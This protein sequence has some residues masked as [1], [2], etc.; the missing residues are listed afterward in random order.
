M[1]T[2]PPPNPTAATSTDTVLDNLRPGSPLQPQISA[3]LNAALKSQLAAA[4]TA[5]QLPALVGLINSMP[6]VDLVA[7]KDLSLHD[8]VSKEVSLPADP[9]EKA[10]LENA[11]G[12]LS[13]STTV[14]D[15][16]GL[17]LTIKAN[18]IAAPEANKA[19]LTTLL[20]ASA[21]LAANSKLI[22]EFVTRYAGFTGSM[23]DFWS[24]LSQDSEFKAVVPELQLT[25]QL[26]TLTLDNPVLVAAL[27]TRYPQMT[28]PRDLTAMSADDWE[29]LITSQHVAIPASISGSTP[30]EQVA[31]YAAA[32]LVTLKEA[33]PGSVFGQALEK[34]LAGSTNTVDRNVSAVLGRASDFD[35]LNT[36]LA[37]YLTQH[38]ATLFTGIAV[39]DQ[40]AV[41]ERLATWQRVARVTTDFP[42]ANTL[43]T[44]G[45]TSAYGI[46][47]TPRASF[48]HAFAGALGSTNAEAI[49]GRAQQISGTAMALFTN[50]RQ[51]LTGV[52]VTSIGDVGGLVWKIQSAPSG[53]PNWQ[54]LFGPLS[55]CTC[56]DCQSVYSAAA[57]F[58]DLLHFLASPSTKN[59]AGQTALH[60]LFVRRPDLQYIKLNCV[61]TNT[62]LPYVDLV[63]EIMESF[64][65]LSSAAF[66]ATLNA[67]TAH[68]TAKS[69]TAADLSVSPEYTLDD[70]YNKYLNTALYPPTLP[71]DRWLLT[72]RTYLGFLGS[73]LYEVMAT[74][75]TAAAPAVYSVPLSK[76]PSIALPSFVTYDSV[77]HRLSLTGAMTADAKTALLALY[78]D[79]DYAI[80][81]SELYA[82]SQ[83][84]ASAATPSRI[85]IACEYLTIT[86]KECEIL[87]GETFAGVPPASPPALC[88]YYGFAAGTSGWEATVAKV[89]TFLQNTA[90]AYDDLVACSV[91]GR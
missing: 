5:A 23:E 74:C 83:K 28:S 66:K 4:A 10:A 45:Y 91:R 42:T 76:Q 81:V 22:D 35:I 72:A 86:E 31:S 70:A 36:N 30:S 19:D 29:Q 40:T 21:S 79:P 32:M 64:V 13:T 61:N 73:S 15:L 24:G 41:T 7:S 90:I 56:A 65:T 71:F 6:A 2:L 51:A 25:L 27:R 16:L 11:I 54:T 34:T 53:I 17:N 38:G 57:Y 37:S 87:T 60:A 89:E 46:A 58:V 9:T 47:G 14:S 8:F 75:Q 59:S 20:G 1:P 44:A 63:N 3:T 55:S 18:P 43:I 84:D 85:A 62:E 82:A 52:N 77:A 48:L 26:G 68:D 50:V 80:A 78:S 33:F 39:N 69:A 88:Q 49:F 67:T 12:K